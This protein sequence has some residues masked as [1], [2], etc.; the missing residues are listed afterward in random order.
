MLLQ[1]PNYTW[2]K[3]LGTAEFHPSLYATK[4]SL[5]DTSSLV[6]LAGDIYV[7]V[8]YLQVLDFHSCLGVSV[9][10]QESMVKGVQ[11]VKPGVWVFITRIKRVTLNSDEVSD[12]GTGYEGEG[13]GYFALI[14]VQG[15]HSGIQA[16]VAS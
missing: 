6:S 4:S 3:H 5:K 10:I 2:F 12:E 13:E 16:K 14:G 8:F 15:L 1:L 9:G 7:I 11:E